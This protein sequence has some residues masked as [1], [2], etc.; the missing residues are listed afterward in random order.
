MIQSSA[1]DPRQVGQA[2]ERAK[3]GRG[4]ARAHAFFVM[5]SVEGRA[6]VKWILDQAGFTAPSY[7]RGDFAETAH[8]E[9]KKHLGNAL[10]QLIHEAD[11]ELYARMM[12]EARGLRA[13]E[14]K[15]DDPD[16]DGAERAIIE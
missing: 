14:P 12:Q 11:P 8:N 3:I 2:K 9:G 5:S 6:F 13:A 10:I 7:V 1:S 16:L 4:G 15:P